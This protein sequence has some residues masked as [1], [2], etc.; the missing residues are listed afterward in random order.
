MLNLQIE[1]I[2]SDTE[3]V[4]TVSETTTQASLSEEEVVQIESKI[5][6]LPEE[7]FLIDE[8]TLA[9]TDS[10]N[11]EIQNEESIEQELSTDTDAEALIAP[12][13][14]RAGISATVALLRKA[15]INILKVSYHLGVRMIERKVSPKQV[16]DAI[17]K[18]KK[19]YDPA[20][21]STV[22][23]YNGVA[24]GRSGNTLTTTYKQ[25]S[26]KSRWIKQ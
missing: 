15:G 13:L 9:Y 22:Y 21:N 6:S 18:G 12:I 3:I 1:D 2:V 19:Y 20:Y 14:V 10:I 26:P 7:K 4:E 8:E 5:L 16:Y 17:T 24:V 11:P 23:H 25:A